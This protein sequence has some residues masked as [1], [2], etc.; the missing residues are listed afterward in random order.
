MKDLQLIASVCMEE[1]DAIGIGYG[2]S[3][4]FKVNSRA[5]KRWGQCS[6]SKITDTYT[7]EISNRLL[8]DYVPEK[9]LMQVIIHELLHTCEG[10]MNHGKTWKRYAELVNETYG[11][12]VSRTDSA[13]GLGVNTEQIGVK[14]QFKCKCCGQVI[15]RMRESKF[16]RNY[17]RYV[18]G[19]C[20]GDFEK[21]F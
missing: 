18:C 7:I 14:H 10:C 6:Y 20:G 17:Q 4:E 16:T 1:L 2:E 12:D 15:N 11:Y 9:S 3:I 13:S 8:E 19:K 5:K 21:I